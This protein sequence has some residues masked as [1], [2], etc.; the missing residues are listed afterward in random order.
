MTVVAEFLTPAVLHPCSNVEA[1][2]H[3]DCL[4]AFLSVRPRL[5]AIAY[6]MLRNASEA[7]DIVQEVW[8]R[9]QS[10]DRSAWAWSWLELRQVSRW[11]NHG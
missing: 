9:W 10:A 5:F 11:I 8:L 7:E 6:R 3:D 4:S 2:A 1:S